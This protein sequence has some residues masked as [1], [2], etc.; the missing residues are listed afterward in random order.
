MKILFFGGKGWIGQQIIK[1]LGH[2]EIYIAISRADDIES[3]EKE[4]TDIRPS[5]IICTIGRTHGVN[6]GKIYPT[7]DYL[8]IKGKLE[9]NVKDNLFGPTILSILC[10]KYDIHLTYMGTGCIFDYDQDHPKEKEIN[11]F[12]E[13]SK[14]NFFG[15]SYSIV[16]GFTDKLM[17]LFSSNVLNVRIRMPITDN[18]HE[19]NFITKIIKYN[20]ICSIANS[21]TVFPDL[22]PCL[23]DMIEKKVTGTINL[24]SPG[25]ISH[26]EILTMYKEIVDPSFE[27]NNFSVEEQSQILMAGRSNNF[28]DTSKLVSMYPHVKNIKDAVRDALYKMNKNS[29]SSSFY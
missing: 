10:C 29:Q 21:M 25:L 5:H 20:K 26:N 9:E 22:L 3:V 8:E 19:R 13:D 6:N 14:P 17:H 18:H 15:S 28:L 4:I 12:T 7:I 16:K 1:L 2:H 11:G 24:V 23:V 27:W